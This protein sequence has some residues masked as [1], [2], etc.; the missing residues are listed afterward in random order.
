MAA[1]QIGEIQKS[2]SSNTNVL[3]AKVLPLLHSRKWEIRTAGGYAVEAIAGTGGHGIWPHSMFAYFSAIWA[4]SMDATD[5]CS[6]TR[7]GQ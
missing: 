6:A 3:L 7:Q 1:E 4:D 2:S 5:R